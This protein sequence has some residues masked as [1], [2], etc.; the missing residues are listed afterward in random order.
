MSNAKFVIWAF[1]GHSGTSCF[2]RDESGLPARCQKYYV[3]ASHDSQLE[4]PPR[5]IELRVCLVGVHLSILQDGRPT[6]HGQMSTAM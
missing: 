1:S 5:L 6:V 2:L 3:E 4:A